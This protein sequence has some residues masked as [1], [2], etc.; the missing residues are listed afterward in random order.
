MNLMDTAQLLGNFGEFVGA[1][2]VVATLG[3]LAVQIRQNT[4]SNYVSRQI[5]AQEQLS[6][7]HEQIMG[8]G[9]LAELVARCRNPELGDLSPGEEERVERFANFYLNAYSG[10]EGSYRQGELSENIYERY[11]VDFKRTLNTYPALSSRMRA[12]VEQYDAENFM[13]FGPLFE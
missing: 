13:I 7:M 1:I 11:R 2:A 10:I 8:N 5:A 12:I 4:R 9:E 3:Y 6:Q